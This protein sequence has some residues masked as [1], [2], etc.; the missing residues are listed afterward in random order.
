MSRRLLL[1][2]IDGTLLSS[3]P[4]ASAAFSGALERV[5]GTAGSAST[6]RFEGRLDPVIVRELMEE[7]GIPAETVEARTR[8]ALDLYLDGLEEALSKSRP[9]LKPGIEALVPRVAADP[10]AVTALLTGNVE[11]GA[12]IKLTAAGLWH[13][14]AFGVWGDEAPAR[15]GLGTVALARAAEK[16]GI[17]F[18]GEDCVVIGD[19]QHD[20]ACGK[21]IGARV[22]AVTTGRTP[23]A[24]LEEAGADVVFDDLSDL[25]AAHAALFS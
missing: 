3:G 10:R 11:R 13:H 25:D 14:F 17:A 18:R 15:T 4:P 9:T 5:F 21:A 2:D 7:A 16:T 6:Y 1:F 8:E 12:R 24:A 22:V 23:R 19:S 20:V